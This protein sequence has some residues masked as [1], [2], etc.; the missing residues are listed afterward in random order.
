MWNLPDETEIFVTA[1]GSPTLCFKRGDG[2]VEK[3]H[4]SG[5]ALSESLYIYHQALLEGLKFGPAKVLSVGLGLGYNELITAAELSRRGDTEFRLWSFETVGEL[6]EGF[7][8]WITEEAQGP[9]PTVFDTVALGVARH[10]KLEPAELKHWLKKA[11]ASGQ[12]QIRKSFPQDLDQVMGNIVFYDAYS[13]KM[14]PELWNEDALVTAFERHLEPA[15]VLA[16]YA[17]TGAL[18]RTLKRLGFRPTPKAGFLGKRESTL[19]IR[20]SLR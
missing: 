9:L 6:R 7:I 4:H 1:D 16:T 3:M 2:Y 15:A 11:Q 14:D 10:F 20:D 19:A 5:G 17:A 13:R 18:N 8:A 12:W